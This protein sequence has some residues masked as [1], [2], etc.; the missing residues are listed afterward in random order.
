MHLNEN[1]SVSSDTLQLYAGRRPLRDIEGLGC[2]GALTDVSSAA[3]RYI[4]R[5]PVS[6]RLIHDTG[7]NHGGQ[8]PAGSDTASSSPPE[9]PAGDTFVSRERN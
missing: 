2:R 1:T 9:W 5:R 6:W 7:S 8:A 4:Q 3:R